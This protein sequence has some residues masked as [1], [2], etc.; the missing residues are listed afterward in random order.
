[1]ADDDDSFWPTDF[2]FSN[3][4]RTNHRPQD[5]EGF[6]SSFAFVDDFS[7]HQKDLQP[8]RGV[9]GGAGGPPERK[10]GVLSK[11][12]REKYACAP[13]DPPQK[14]SHTSKNVAGALERKLHRRKKSFGA[15]DI[16]SL[17]LSA[18]Q[19][20][21]SQAS[22]VSTK[23]ES[24][25]NT[26]DNSALS[27]GSAH[28]TPTNF[29]KPM[30]SL[31]ALSS[32]SAH[33]TP[34]HFN[35]AM[36]SLV[37][38]PSTPSSLASPGQRRKSASSG[39]RM[40]S[41]SSG[42][43]RKNSRD[44]GYTGALEDASLCSASGSNHHT[45]NGLLRRQ[46]LKVSSSEMEDKLVGMWGDK[47]NSP[48]L[49]DA[50]SSFL[51]I[52]PEELRGL[53]QPES[54]RRASRERS[55]RPGSP[56]PGRIGSVGRR[57]PNGQGTTESAQAL[58][59]SSKGSRRG[60]R[61]VRH[62]SSGAREPSENGQ[63]RRRSDLIERASEG[64]N[65]SYVCYEKSASFHDE[66][67]D[68]DWDSFSHRSEDISIADSTLI[69]RF[70]RMAGRGQR[71]D[72]SSSEHSASSARGNRLNQDL[73]SSEH[74]SH[75]SRRERRKDPLSLSEHGTLSV[76][77]EPKK[78]P[79]SYSEHVSRRST[80]THRKEGEARP[81]R[82][83][84]CPSIHVAVQKEDPLSSRSEQAPRKSTQNR[85]KEGE[86]RPRRRGSC[87]SLQDAIQNEDPPSSRSEQVPRRST[88][89]RR[90]EG[91]PRPRRRGSCPSLQDVMQN[92]D[93]PSSRSENV[94]RRSTEN[95]RKEG[96]PRLRSRSRGACPSLQGAAQNENHLSAR[97]EHNSR[98]STQNR[99][100]EGEPRPKRRGSCPSL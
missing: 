100:K 86:P 89:N 33:D 84:S 77:Q 8:E 87:P 82:R 92:E 1:M 15:L 91:E 36:S 16:G 53:I 56:K 80:Q 93:P 3:D 98:R 10:R 13:V 20:D 76:R 64:R 49:H 29:N 59:S 61:L 78:D 85:R 52:S 23:L 35:K 54:D 31:V 21:Q 60:S 42:Q 55:Q 17:G 62:G 48:P 34:A 99:R 94:S 44:S 83:G 74:G 41:A 19:H 50:L 97:G 46:T 73:S 58:R 24:S 70:S 39:Q 65:P 75:S 47:P 2:H 26:V 67:G 18:S 5:D 66:N 96:E 6:S 30:S 38:A 68:Y 95:S 71:N 32:G 63:R 22:T 69:E 40:K 14:P 4:P 9:S 25:W 43:R 57:A 79:L 27:S 88:Q 81:R 72:I 7:P 90:K 12:L 45:P 37:D 11:A 51:N 28:D